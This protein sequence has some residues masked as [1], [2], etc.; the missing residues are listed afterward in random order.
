MLLSQDLLEGRVLLG[1]AGAAGKLLELQP[2]LVVLVLR[3]EEG[4]RLAGVDEHRDPELGALVPDGIQAR[5]V[6]RHAPA[7][8]V[9]HGQAQVL[10]DLQA[11]RAVAHVLGELRGGPISPPGRLNPLVVQVGEDDEA[12]GVAARQ[13]AVALLELGPLRTA[14]V[15]HHL[16]VDPVHV[17]HQAGGLL[18]GHVAIL[19]IVHVDERVLRAFW[20][21]LG[22]DERGLRLVL[23]DRHRLRREARGRQRPHPEPQE[24]KDE[25]RPRGVSESGVFHGCSFPCAGSPRSGACD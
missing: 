11:A 17:G 4:T 8:R 22:H 24:T 23:L 16:E 12:A 14:Q 2:P 3:L 5:I 20:L 9:G 10:E 19:V 6:D 1:R 25:H 18:D 7:A 15:H 21:V 13:V